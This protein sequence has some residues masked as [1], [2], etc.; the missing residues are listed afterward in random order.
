MP[1]S[2]CSE[3]V[4]AMEACRSR[5]IG[6]I[7]AGRC[8]R[9]IRRE[10]AEDVCQMVMTNIWLQCLD[11]HAF[12][13]ATICG[14]MSVASCRVLADYPAPRL[15][16]DYLTV[17]SHESGMTVEEFRQH[18]DVAPAGAWASVRTAEEEMG[19]RRRP[20]HV[21]G[22]GD[23]VRFT[24]YRV[25]HDPI[26]ALAIRG[27]DLIEYEPFFEA[28]RECLAMLSDQDRA[29]IAASDNGQSYADIASAQRL[30]VHQVNNRL[31]RARVA[32]RECFR[33]KTGF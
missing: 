21:L 12:E 20:A 23:V 19:R 18:R 4:N 6:Q 25:N 24:W 27:E 31:H 7:T 14:L 10:D 26:E 22:N 3:L 5:T 15:R 1:N 8:R 2:H 13:P 11:G 17:E 30:T 28:Y 9:A 29:L 16:S 33:S 32:I